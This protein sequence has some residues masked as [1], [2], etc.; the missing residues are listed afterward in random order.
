[1]NTHVI[2]RLFCATAT[3]I[4]IGACGGDGAV[5]SA[6]SPGD[7]DDVSTED[8][9]KANVTPGV[10]K[11]YE[12]AHT[13]P[14]PDCDRHTSLELKAAHQSTATFEEVLRGGCEIMV[15]PDRRTYR[16]KLAGTSCG[17]RVYTGSITKGG[18]RSEV[19]ITD[20]RARTCENVVEARVVVEETRFGFTTKQYSSDTAGA[21]RVW[22]S[23]AQTLVAQT[24]GGGGLFDPAPPTGSTCRYGAQKYTLDVATKKVAWEVCEVVDDDTPFTTKSGTTMLTTKQLAFVSAA[25]GNV[26]LSAST[27]C[28]NDKPLLS[29]TVTSPSQGVQ[30][31]KDSFYACKGGSA[32]YV[33]N[34]SDVFDA[35][36]DVLSRPPPVE[37]R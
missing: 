21:E 16:L 36:R 14:S 24:S 9:V 32:P 37:Y 4:V 2:S 28:G 6:N 33:D 12:E 18:D 11:L 15:V 19:T 23:D 7:G 25:M 10:F 27:I 31:F 20:N 26:T 13:T 1:M 35:F 29:I 30:T 22:P 3:A 8:A 17:T 5:D 34:I